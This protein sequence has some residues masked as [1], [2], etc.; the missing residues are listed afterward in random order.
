MGKNDTKRD[1]ITIPLTI[2]KFKHR[3]LYYYIQQ[4]KQG[5]RSFAMRELMEAGMETDHRYNFVDNLIDDDFET[6]NEENK[7]YVFPPKE[8][9]KKEASNKSTNE[10]TK[11]SENKKTHAVTAQNKKKAPVDILKNVK[12][13]K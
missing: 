9:S 1:S 5:Q 10:T 3:E 13:F 2:N 12:V 11:G 6:I 7:T 8:P 4:I